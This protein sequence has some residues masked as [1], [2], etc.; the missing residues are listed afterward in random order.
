MELAAMR[1]HTIAWR[2]RDGVKRN[3]LARVVSPL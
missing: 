2:W 1:G 3:P